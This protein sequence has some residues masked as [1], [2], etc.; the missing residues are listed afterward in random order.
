MR[1]FRAMTATPAPGPVIPGHAPDH[2]LAAQPPG[3]RMYGHA[4]FA[5]CCA[6]SFTPGNAG[7]GI[8]A[9][10][11][12][13]GQITSGLVLAAVICRFAGSDPALA[14]T[15]LESGEPVAGCGR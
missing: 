15:S 12:N 6:S 11:P 4:S 2:P 13:T 10:A 8:R 1:P 9:R 5:L 7:H 14:D 3:R